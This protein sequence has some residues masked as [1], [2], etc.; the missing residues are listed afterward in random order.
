[1]PAHDVPNILED[2]VTMAVRMMA[3]KMYQ[4]YCDNSGNKNFQGN[5]CPTWEDLPTLIRAHWCAAAIAAMPHL[6]NP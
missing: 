2:K 3:R 1:M 6:N 4:G 5:A